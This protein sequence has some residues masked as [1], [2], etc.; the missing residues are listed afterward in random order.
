MDEFKLAKSVG[1]VGP[2]PKEETVLKKLRSRLRESR[3][4]LGLGQKPL[5]KEERET[6]LLNC[7]GK[8]LAAA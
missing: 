3:L 7:A 2:E 4:P 6:L 8:G 5:T 1:L